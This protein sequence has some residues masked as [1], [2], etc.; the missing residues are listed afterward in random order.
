MLLR[1]CTLEWEELQLSK[2]IL[3]FA[4][5]AMLS[6]LSFPAE[7]Q[8]AG[9][10]PRIGLLISASASTDQH[11]A[12]AFSKGLR[13]LGYLEGQN[14]AV[15]YR[16]AEGKVDE[17]PALAAEL[18]RLKVD[19]IVVEGGQGIR[20]AQRASSTI[21]IIMTTVSDPVALGFAASLARP[22]GNI[23]GLSLFAPRHVGKL[24]AR[25][26]GGPADAHTRWRSGTVEEG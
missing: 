2:K 11:R 17:L 25:E 13:D 19:I 22:G 1:I 24:H 8:Q 5:G 4:L 21:P 15:E 3:V 6:A 9:K 14:I 20:A 18:V 16:F 7:A 12:T 23:T 26:P 10:I